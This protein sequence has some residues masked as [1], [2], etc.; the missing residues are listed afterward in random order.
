LFVFQDYSVTDSL[1]TSE[2]NKESEEGTD[3]YFEILTNWGNPKYLG[4]TEVCVKVCNSCNHKQSHSVPQRAV[5]LY[6]DLQAPH[7]CNIPGTHTPTAF[8]ILPTFQ[9]CFYNFIH[10]AK[11]KIFLFPDQQQHLHG[12]RKR[13]V[14]I[15]VVLGLTSIHV[16][17]TTCIA[18]Y[19]SLDSVL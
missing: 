15:N 19:L 9:T 5:L 4:L 18:H 13:R 14:L 1:D 11:K 6:L 16:L 2:N 7:A 3:V 12:D 17:H 10:V 8:L